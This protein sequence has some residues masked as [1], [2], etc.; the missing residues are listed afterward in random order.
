MSKQNINEDLKRFNKILN[1]NPN[2]GLVNES[3]ADLG[4]MY[5]IEQCNCYEVLKQKFSEAINE[6]YGSLEEEVPSYNEGDSD[7]DEAVDNL[8][9]RATGLVGPPGF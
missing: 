8:I 7:H 3:S 1:Y 9:L 6:F 2:K 4:L 5:E